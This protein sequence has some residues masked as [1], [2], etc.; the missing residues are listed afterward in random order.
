MRC[1][2]C[3]TSGVIVNHVRTCSLTEQS[4]RSIGAD[5]PATASQYAP[6]HGGYPGT[7]P[8]HDDPNHGLAWGGVAR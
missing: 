4:I 5:R 2:H 1:G 3:K 7:V 6:V 8:G